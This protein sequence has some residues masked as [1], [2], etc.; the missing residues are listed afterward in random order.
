MLCCSLACPP[1]QADDLK[2]GEP[3]PALQL[4]TLDGQT[5]DTKAL[6]GKVVIVA[7]WA[8]WCAPCRAELPLL[9]AYAEQHRDLEVLGFSLDDA[10]GLDEVRRISTA[11]D[12]PVGLAGSPWQG[13]YGRIWHVPVSFVIDR[14]GRLAYNGWDDDHPAWT[15]DK[16]HRIVDPLLR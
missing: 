16:L 1:A 6:A 5:I 3:A 2:I 4:H 9:S 10:G 14:H 8:S 13:A 15:A 7:F 12:F 11:L